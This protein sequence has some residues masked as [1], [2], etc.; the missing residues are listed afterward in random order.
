MITRELKLKLTKIQNKQLDEWLRILTSIYNWG[1]RKIELNSLDKIYFSKFDFV[2]LLSNHGFRLGIPS[3]TI[4]GVLTRAHHAW[5][6]YFK[7][8]SKKPRLKSIH[9]RLV[10]LPFPD[11]IKN[12][13]EKSVYL[14]GL[15]SVKYHKQSL[16]EGK[17]KCGRII[18]RA[19]G[20][21]LQ[22]TIDAKHSFKVKET[23]STIGIDT[24]FKNLAILSDG[25]KYENNR[26]FIEGQTRLAQAQ[27][28]KNKK[29]TARIHERITNRR[30]DYNHKI[31]KEIVQNNQ[32]I[33]ITKDNLRNQA[34]IF[35]KSVSDAGISQLRTFIV[36][37]GANHGRVVKL[38]DTKNT[39]KTC[40]TCGRLSGPTGLGGLAVRSWECMDCGSVHDRDINAAKNI[41][42]FGLG[43]NLE[44]KANNYNNISSEM[45]AQEGRQ[46]QDMD[47]G[48]I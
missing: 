34:K 26:F 4:Q 37:K 39:T 40:S 5:Q 29:L 25:T 9:N 6:R 42:N 17:I 19:S 16:P 46:Y 36:Y 20:W 41:L 28:G 23:N 2:N 8:T 33:Y 45:A 47:G 18:K 44:Q 21:Y 27:R 1:I 38:V 10:S 11:P 12:I 48:L 15:K 7:K 22:L 14:P 30:K 35:G 13:T 24:G 32:E 3:H 43:Y 31:S